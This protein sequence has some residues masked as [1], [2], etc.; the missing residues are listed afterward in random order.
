MLHYIEAPN[1]DQPRFPSVFLGGG[2]TNCPDWQAE[3]IMYLTALRRPVTVYNP[4][5]ARFPIDDPAESV[6][7]TEWQFV[8]LR[9]AHIASFWFSRGSLN[10]IVLLQFGSALQRSRQP[11]V[12]GID[13][14]YERK[15]DVEIQT[16]LLRPEVDIAYDIPTFVQK[17]ARHLPRSPKK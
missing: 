2:I 17:I 7:H 8:R 4:R 12:V 10:P 14:Q 15:V 9:L 16:A 13:P 1:L 5:R 11:L 3:A 6:R